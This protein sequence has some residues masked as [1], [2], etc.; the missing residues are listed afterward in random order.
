ME[1][2][3]F[4]VIYN[5]YHQTVLNYLQYKGINSDI[6]CEICND[7]FLKVHKSINEYDSKQSE[8]KTW[9][10]NIAKNA[11]I[12]HFRSSE[13]KRKLQTENVSDFVDSEGRELYS[14]KSDMSTDYNV[15]SIELWNKLKNVIST[16]NSTQ[17]KVAELFLIGGL[18]YE[19]VAKICDIPLNSVKGNMTRVREICQK[20]FQS[21]HY[22]YAK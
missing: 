9:L 16:M 4:D 19:E 7:V 22:Q 6:A 17:Q 21:E 12:D 8:F 5:K 14:F 1:T 10:F 13:N 2:L 11:M 18:S 20:N 3:N 15:E